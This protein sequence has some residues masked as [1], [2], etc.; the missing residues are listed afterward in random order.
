[1]SKKSLVSGGP[2]ALNTSVGAEAS[3]ESAT[4]SRVSPEGNECKWA[5]FGPTHC[6][7][8]IP[9][10]CPAET[11]ICDDTFTTTQNVSPK[12]AGCPVAGP[13]VRGVPLRFPQEHSR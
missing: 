9:I 8:G 2:R 11:I 10:T 3:I 12:T 13:C 5:A 4:D 7:R 1:M 6:A